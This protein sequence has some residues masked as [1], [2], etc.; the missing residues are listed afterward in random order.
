MQK[1]TPF[2]D[3]HWLF[4]GGYGSRDLCRLNLEEAVYLYKCVR[5]FEN[6]FVVEV[7]RYHG[8]T[9]ILL[10]AAGARVLSIDNHSKDKKSAEYDDKLNE[11]YGSD[12][13][14]MVV[15]DSGKY[16]TKG[17]GVDVLFI[18]GGHR[19]EEVK[20][21]F[22][23]WYGAVRGDILFHDINLPGVAKLVNENKTR[24][25]EVRKVTS[26]YHVRKDNSHR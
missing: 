13:L 11:K 12:R 21:D 22:D 24:F 10:L 19:Y 7:G 26:L 3:I 20:R 14:E 6:P 8:G 9:T 25:E 23:N 16:P 18:D 17:L 15:G 1:I 2:E 4:T 5:G